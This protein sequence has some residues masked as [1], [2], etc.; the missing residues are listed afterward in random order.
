MEIFPKQGNSVRSF[1]GEPVTISA[2]IQPATPNPA[3]PS[4]IQPATPNPLP[5]SPVPQNNS[6]SWTELSPDAL[7]VAAYIL[8]AA[9]IAEDIATLGA[10]VADDV[11]SFALAA[12]MLRLA[13]SRQAVQSV[14]RT[15]TQIV[16]QGG[17]TAAGAI[18]A[19]AISAAPAYAK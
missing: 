17:R 12:A 16:I 2:A 15:G 6:N 10:G 11:A 14:V 19:G 9:T 8:I 5:G 3:I 1:V 13:A 4:S 18:G 7:K